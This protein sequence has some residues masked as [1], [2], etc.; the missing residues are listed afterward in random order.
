MPRRRPHVKAGR[1]KWTDPAQPAA[2]QPGCRSPSWE[3][4]KTCRVFSPPTHNLICSYEI[5]SELLRWGL[6]HEMRS[7]QMKGRETQMPRVSLASTK[8]KLKPERYRAHVMWGANY[9]RYG[10]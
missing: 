4:V 10:S 2:C 1:P 9:P 6:G 3:V 8:A 5:Y 7:D